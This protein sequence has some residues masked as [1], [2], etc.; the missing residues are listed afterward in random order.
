MMQYYAVFKHRLEMLTPFFD[1]KSAAIVVE[2]SKHRE[3]LQFAPDM[4]WPPIISNGNKSSTTAKHLQLESLDGQVVVAEIPES[5]PQFQ[6]LVHG[7]VVHPT[8]FHFPV[9]KPNEDLLATTEFTILGVRDFP[10][11]LT[12]SFSLLTDYIMG[13]LPLRKEPMIDYLVLLGDDTIMQTSVCNDDWIAM[14]APFVQNVVIVPSQM[15]TR[16]LRALPQPAIHQCFFP[17]STQ[18]AHV[19]CAPNPCLIH[20]D[21]VVAFAGFTPHVMECRVVAPNFSNITS[22]ATKSERLVLN[23]PNTF[24]ALSFD[25]VPS[26]KNT[27]TALLV[28]KKQ[29]TTR[30]ME[31]KLV[32]A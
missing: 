20:N 16:T 27:H 10:D 32:F 11:N 2:K 4:R 14:I 18:M 29:N 5:H 6:K 8:T 24:I 21:C 13:I 19:S 17:K 26:F 3:Q 1:D 25:N 12:L 28:R 15:S 7:M 23:S 9:I 22:E 31:E 30:E